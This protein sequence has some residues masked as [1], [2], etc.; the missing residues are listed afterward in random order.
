MTSVNLIRGCLV[1]VGRHSG[2]RCK[3]SGRNNDVCTETGD[4][5]FF[6]VTM[7]LIV[8]TIDGWTTVCAIIIVF[9]FIIG[10]NLICI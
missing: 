5:I 7:A 4:G 8:L 1:I 2:N 9:L 3:D 6:I 10:S